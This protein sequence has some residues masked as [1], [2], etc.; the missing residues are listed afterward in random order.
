MIV[1]DPRSPRGIVWLASYPRSGNTWTRAF[2]NSLYH[3]IVGTPADEIDLNRMS[4]FTAS[5]T[6][7]TAYEKYLG[8][9]VME[10]GDM[11]I[12]G[13]RPRVQQNIFDRA[14][15]TVLIKTHNAMV[16]D[17]GAPLINRRVSSGAIYVIRNP[18]DVAISFAHFRGVSIDQTI[19]DMAT[20]GY[21]FPTTREYVYIVTASWSEHVVSWT[22]PSSPAVLVVRYEDMI[23]K[24]IETFGSIATHVLMRPTQ[25]QLAA[26]I[27][28]TSFEKLREAE[29]KTGFRER[30][31]STPQFFRE[32]RVDQW[33][34]RLTVAQVDR[35]VAAHGAEMRRFNY[36]PR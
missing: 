11:A 2:L 17:R 33:R 7:A 25:D 19:D 3:V 30:P 5:E 22:N 26:A 9:P 14:R 28:R 6:A 36:L 13:L 10:A 12:A 32:G 20:P 4:D 15:G 29:R 34:D 23:E 27:D 24:P 31:S 16:A 1:V 18:L 21:G 35:V 8:R